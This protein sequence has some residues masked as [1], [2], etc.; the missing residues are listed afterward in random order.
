M[1][2]LFLTDRAMDDL[3]E[4]YEY[5]VEKWGESIA[6]KYIIAFEDAFSILKS[7]KGILKVNKKISSRFRVYFVQKHCLICEVI[8]NKI[9]V[10][11]IKHSSM[12]ILERLKKLEPSLDD[13]VQF[14]IK[15]L[16]S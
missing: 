3:H 1:S 6:S 2:Q 13:E 14:L 7:R 4:I 9:I 12:N 11:T 8:E 16:K 15:K 5:S 10:I